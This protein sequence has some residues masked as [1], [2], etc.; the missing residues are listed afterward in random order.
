MGY[1]KKEWNRYRK[2][3]G[4]IEIV[5]RDDSR[6]KIDMLRASNNKDFRVCLNILKKYGFESNKKS[7]F[8]KEEI[9]KEIES[10]K[11]LFKSD[12]KW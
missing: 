8:D 10:Q 5:I 11:N 6:R 1:E 9:K 12:V 4:R 3:A 2:R 7:E